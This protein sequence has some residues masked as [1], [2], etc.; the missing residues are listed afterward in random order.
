MPRKTRHTMLPG[1]G[2]VVLNVVMLVILAAVYHYALRDA[3]AMKSKNTG[4]L[5]VLV[6]CYLAFLAVSIFDAVYDRHVE[7]SAAAEG[8]TRPET[9]P[10]PAS[11]EATRKGE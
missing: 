5:P 10:P 11:R 4:F 6:I 1:W 9:P 3:A 2:Y 8:R 7:K